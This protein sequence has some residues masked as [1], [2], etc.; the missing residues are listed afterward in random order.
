MSLAYPD[1][2]EITPVTLSDTYHEQT[3]GVSFQ[4]K[5]CVEDD[6][7][8]RFGPNGE[9]IDPVVLIQFP[10]KTSVHKGDYVRIFH[11]HAAST[12]RGISH[13][14]RRRQGI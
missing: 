1:I 13:Q 4:S 11:P 7:K 14:C 10:A 2:A 9:P 5:A 8:L 3:E 6:S 12:C